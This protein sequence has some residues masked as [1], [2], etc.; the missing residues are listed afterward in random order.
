[1]AKHIEGLMT[2]TIR[3]GLRIK[4]EK[5][6]RNITLYVPCLTGGQVKVIFHRVEEYSLP[7]EYTLI[8]TCT[9]DSERYEFEYYAP[10]GNR[11]ATIIHFDPVKKTIPV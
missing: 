7:N 6:I 8:G 2:P 4:K 11:N 5:G 3:N 10:F 9:I 1:M